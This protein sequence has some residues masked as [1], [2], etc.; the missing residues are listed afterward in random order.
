[1]INCTN[2]TATDNCSPVGDITIY[3][4]N[5]IWTAID[6]SGNIT[7]ATANCSVQGAGKVATSQATAE[8][9][10]AQKVTQEKTKAPVAVAVKIPLQDITV[11]TIPNPFN[12]KVRFVVTAPEA[13]YG[14][15]D[16]MNMLG[17][18]VK[19]V[20]QGQIHAGGQSFE[21]VLPKSRNATLFYI[22][23]LNGKQVT[24]KLV[25]MN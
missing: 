10:E 12:D 3:L 8:Q 9:Q 1:V 16:V 15:L 21:M 4:N 17:Q 2:G 14:T 24:G 18:K 25:Q 19:T 22:L 6:G 23:K 13:G 11:Q 20:F 5:G 7:T